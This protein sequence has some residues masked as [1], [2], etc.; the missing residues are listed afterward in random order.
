MSKKETSAE[1]A[2]KAARIM[3]MAKKGGPIQANRPALRLAL[4]CLDREDLMKS[5]QLNDE[6]ENAAADQL[7]DAINEVLKPYFD[8]AE[9]VAAS[10]VGQREAP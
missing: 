1:I 4:R 7:L 8:D 3:A 5:K 10:A 2:S 6:T 9:S